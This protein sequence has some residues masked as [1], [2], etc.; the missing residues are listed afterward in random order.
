MAFA[1]RIRSITILSNAMWIGLLVLLFLAV[2][3]GDLP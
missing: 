2:L 1:P 3:I